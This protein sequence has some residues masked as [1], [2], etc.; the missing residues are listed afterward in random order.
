[1]DK[2]DFTPWLVYFT[3]GIIDELLRV[4]KELDKEILTP[5]SILTEDEKKMLA[6]I[7][8]N[9]FIT[10]RIYSTLTKRAKATRNLDFQKLISMG[11]I[12]MEGKGKA[13]YYKRV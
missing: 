12:R 1:M 8:M 5:Q 3:G 6:Y 4:S 2:I 11:I 13:T 9:G 7:D 10:D